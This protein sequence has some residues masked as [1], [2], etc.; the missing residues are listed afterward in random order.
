MRVPKLNKIFFLVFVTALL[1]TAPIAGYGPGLAEEKPVT[2]IIHGVEI[3][4]KNPPIMMSNRVFLPDQFVAD[5][6]GYPFKWEPKTRSVRMGVPPTGV[7]MVRELPAFCG[8]S[9]ATPVK[10]RAKSY[11]GGFKID[12]KNTVRWSIKGVLDSVTFSF[13]LPDGHK[14]KSVGFKLLADGKIVAEETVD[15]DE[16]LKEFTFDVSN[17]KVLTVK[18]NDTPGGVLINPRGYQS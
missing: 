7:E 9:L 15:R 2:I 17:V 5:I 16:G 18:Y 14:G 10:V 11:A 1:L 8:K 6:L 13:G 4:G 3:A 12:G